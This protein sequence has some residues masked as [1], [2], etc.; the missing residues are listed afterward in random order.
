MNLIQL[1]SLLT[2]HPRN[3]RELKSLVL[4]LAIR[5]RLTSN[6]RIKNQTGLNQEAIFREIQ[7]SDLVDSS[8]LEVG[9]IFNSFRKD[10]FLPN[11]WFLTSF[12][13]LALIVRGGSPRPIKDYLTDDQAGY[14]W[15]K[16]G[17]TEANGKYIYQT[18][19]K[20]IEE[21]L[22][23]SRL[24]KPGDFLLTNSMS[25]GRP[26]I[27][28]I[29]GCIHD[30]W[31]LIR[32][33]PSI[34]DKDY[35]YLLL[36]SPFLKREFEKSAAG[37]VVKNL[38][39]EKVKNAPVYVPPLP[40]QTAI[41]EVVNSLFAEI[42]QLEA[43]TQARL[44][45]QQDYVTAI[46]RELTTGS[47]AVVWPKLVPQFA[48]HF[49]TPAA[50]KRLRE[51]ILQLAVQGKLTTHWRHQ[52]AAG[53]PASVLLERIQAEKALLIR[54]KVIKKEKPLP[55]ITA[56]EIP[57][58]LPEGWVWCRLDDIASIIGGAAKG[59]KYKDET[60]SVPYLRVANVQRGY[61]DLS[62][63][64]DLEVN[65]LDIQ[66][67]QLL[68]NDLLMIE[69]GDPD[70]LGRCAIWQNEIPGCIHQNHVF[71]VRQ[72]L[73]DF[74]SPQYLM[75]FINSPVCRQYYENCAK[76]TTNLASINKTQM[77]TTLI[78]LPP[79]AEQPA[80]VSKVND[81]LALC[82]ALEI[83]LATQDGQLRDLMDSV[84]RNA[85]IDNAEMP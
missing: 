3:A 40:E 2:T 36:S 41:V 65:E 58:E 31:L 20:I 8:H 76:R 43:Q 77:R 57:F 54:E 33:I 62:V 44:G 35:L 23:K 6:W 11:S 74:L 38:N 85:V 63:I 1:L 50:V 61:L 67:Y 42:D 79:L 7:I 24:V 13:N 14:N 17:D 53:E 60:Y 5:G 22:K 56:E 69:G 49:T 34:L 70:K 37:G 39:I 66:K 27:S 59:K 12:R 32:Q 84:V 71:R 64:K 16:I 45:T 82:D 73:I 46:L 19:E 10:D 68:K 78:P 55:P 72:Y 28:K 83:A 48:T 25:F 29:T 30:G 51:S 18:R 4:Q 75:T 81:L 80:I 26:Y 21:G 15:I 52:Q 9:N 47:P